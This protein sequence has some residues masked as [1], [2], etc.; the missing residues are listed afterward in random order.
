[1]PKKRE[2]AK[3]RGHNTRSR[4]T[5]RPHLTKAR[6]AKHMTQTDVA[7]LLTISLASYSAYETGFRTP[8]LWTAARIS[9]ILETPIKDLFPELYSEAEAEVTS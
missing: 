7:K 1:M 5:G 6:L 8:P 3:R 2:K 4:F 9:E